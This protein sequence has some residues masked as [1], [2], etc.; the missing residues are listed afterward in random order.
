MKLEEAGVL[1]DRIV[2]C[3][4]PL[5]DRV[6]VVGSIRRKRADVHDIDIVAIPQTPWHWPM[7]VKCLK[8]ELNMTL[9]RTGPELATLG[10]K[11]VDLPVDIY[12]AR[13]TTWGV[14]LL[15]RTGSKGHN[16]KLCS[17]AKRMGM[18]LSAKEGVVKDGKIIASRSEEEIFKAL[19]MEFVNPEEREV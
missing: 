13:A 9:I 3:I 6:Q 12:R 7:I 8:K 18:M 1:A 15:I 10:F 4:Q 5:C 11:D 19:D 17:R 14:L 16:I 2:Y